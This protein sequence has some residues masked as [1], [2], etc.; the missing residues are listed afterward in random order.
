MLKRDKTFSERVEKDRIIHNLRND[1]FWR[2]V[3]EAL[4]QA[5]PLNVSTEPGVTGRK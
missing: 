3:R 1:D 4:L 2:Q 5:R